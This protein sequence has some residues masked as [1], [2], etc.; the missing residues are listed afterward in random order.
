MGDVV[1]NLPQSESKS[2]LSNS[3]LKDYIISQLK[4]NDITW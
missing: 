3:N 4:K 1:I 2:R